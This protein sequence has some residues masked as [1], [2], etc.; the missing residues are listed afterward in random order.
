MLS[1]VPD[2]LWWETSI[3]IDLY[4]PSNTYSVI[5]PQKQLSPTTIPSII[6]FFHLSFG[7]YVA[8]LVVLFMLSPVWV[9]KGSKIKDTLH[10]LLKIGKH[11]R[12]F[13]IINKS[14]RKSQK[15]SNNRLAKQPTMLPMSQPCWRP[16]LFMLVPLSF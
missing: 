16:N 7:L 13:F 5:Q 6:H 11:K 2:Y 9:F 3:N 4:H 8:H 15:D 12:Q 14:E 1:V 10:V